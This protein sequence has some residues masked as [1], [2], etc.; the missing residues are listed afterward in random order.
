[1]SFA[2]AV[3]DSVFSVGI[4]SSRVQVAGGFLSLGL[5]A[6]ISYLPVL[7]S[8]F[9]TAALSAG[10][11]LIITAFGVLIFMADESRKAWHRA[12]QNGS[13]CRLMQ[14]CKRYRQD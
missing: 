11:W 13:P 7:Q 14:R 12:G 10:D 9:N 6:A 2:V 8:V 3:R 1:M 4:F 5:I